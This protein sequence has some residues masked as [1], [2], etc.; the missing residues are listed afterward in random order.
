MNILI[1]ERLVNENRKRTKQ[2]QEFEL[3]DTGKCVKI[4]RIKSRLVTYE[5]AFSPFLNLRYKAISVSL[6][7]KRIQYDKRKKKMNSKKKNKEKKKNFAET[8]DYSELKRVL[9]I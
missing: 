2:E 3:A 6:L 1:S 8:R 7:P 5:N 4:L 9:R